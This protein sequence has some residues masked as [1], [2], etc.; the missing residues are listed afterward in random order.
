MA[1]LFTLGFLCCQSIVFGLQLSKSAAASS[2]FYFEL[3]AISLVPLPSA[4]AILLTYSWR[5]RSSASLIDLA[6]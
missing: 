4:V 3:L 2:G 1:V 5:S 6:C